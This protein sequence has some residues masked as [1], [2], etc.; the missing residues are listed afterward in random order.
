MRRGRAQVETD[1]TEVVPCFATC[2]VDDDQGAA[3]CDGVRQEIVGSAVDAVMC[4]D[5]R[6]IGVRVHKVEREFGLGE[7]FWPVVNRERWVGGC[8]DAEKVSFESLYTTF[9]GVR[10]LL[11]W[12]NGVMN[13]VLGREES[14]EGS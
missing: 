5:G 2:V 4:G 13:D 8:Q 14:E 11:V 12:W 6:E 7:K 1:E 3:G 9:R 10:S